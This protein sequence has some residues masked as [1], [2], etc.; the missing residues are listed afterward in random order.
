M[1][2]VAEVAAM[3]TDLAF[4]PAAATFLP[5]RPCSARILAE[6]ISHL[7]FCF[8]IRN[9]PAYLGDCLW[10]EGWNGGSRLEVGHFNLPVL[11]HSHSA[12]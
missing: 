2:I 10:S 7:S 8:V 9:R 3:E 1:K 6:L 11:P 12:V 4:C 5:S